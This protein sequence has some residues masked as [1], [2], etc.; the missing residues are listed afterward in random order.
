MAN[1]DDIRAGRALVEVF[2]DDSQLQQGLAEV[3][4]ESIRGAIALQIFGRGGTQFLPMALGGAEEIRA[5]REEA[6]KLNARFDAENA[7]NGVCMRKGCSLSKWANLFCA[8]CVFAL[9]FSVR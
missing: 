4:D 1:Q 9:S 3:E 6:H 8:F 5:M 2:T 7:A